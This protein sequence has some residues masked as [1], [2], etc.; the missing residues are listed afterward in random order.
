MAVRHGG[1]T[2][3]LDGNNLM[4]G[5]RQDS[6]RDERDKFLE[7]LLKYRL[8]KPSCVVFDGPPP[9]QGSPERTRGVLKVIY[10]APETADTVL[11]LRARPGDTVVTSDFALQGSCRAAG[12]RVLTGNEFLRGL[13]PLGGKTAEKPAGVTDSEVEAWMALFGEGRE[14]P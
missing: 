8:P 14:G 12:A 11:R 10:A 4:G 13:V 7:E 9:R 1:G 2:T 5:A 6:G 3:Y